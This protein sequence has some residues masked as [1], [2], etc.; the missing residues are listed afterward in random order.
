MSGREHRTPKADPHLSAAWEHTPEG[1]GYSEVSPDGLLILCTLWRD[2]A[3]TWPC[4]PEPLTADAVEVLRMA[5]EARGLDSTPVFAHWLER[6]RWTALER[7]PPTTRAALRV[8]ERLRMKLQLEVA[9]RGGTVPEG[10]SAV[11]DAGKSKQ[12]GERKGRQHD[13][14]PIPPNLIQWNGK[15]HDLPPRQWSL[16]RYMWERESAG[17]AAV[18]TKVWGNDVEDRAATVSSTMTKLHDNL[19]RKGIALPW[20]LGRKNGRIVK[21]E[22]S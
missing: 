3:G 7:L 18:V 8:V 2:M 10:A 9:Q 6:S 13:D 17:E 14:G 16:L 12:R 21:K 20:R 15:T 11:P 22:L 4:D 1:L 5:M 19:R